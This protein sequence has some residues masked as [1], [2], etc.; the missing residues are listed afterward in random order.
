M[1]RLLLAFSC[2]SV[3]ASCGGGGG[4][5]TT[6]PTPTPTISLSASATSG[7]IA[8]GASSTT[9]LSVSRGGGFSGA[10]ALSAA[11]APSGVTVSFAPSSLASGSTSSTATISVDGTAAA[12][13]STITITASGSSVSSQSV[14]Y[15][16]TIPAPAI[17]LTA[18]AGT[19]TTAQGSSATVPLTITRVNGASSDV[20][21]SATGAPTGTTVSFAP[22]TL[23]SAQ[24][25]S[26][27]TLDVGSATAVG[28][29]SITVSAASSGVTTQTATVQLT[30]TA[31]ATPGYTLTATPAALSVT[32]GNGGTSAIAVARTGGFAGNVT[33]ALEGSPSG[34]TGSFAPNPATGNTSTLTITTTG[35]VTPGTYNLT[36]RGTAA[37]QTD[38]TIAF[39]LTVNAAPGITLTLAP[40]VLSIAQSANA[41]TA[42][43]LA[44]VGGLTG[45]VALSAT[46]APAGMTVVFNPA[47]VTA[48]AST[49]TVTVG[50]SVA[51][52][53]YPIT[54]TGTGTGSVTGTVTLTVTVTVAQGFTL[55]ATNASAVQGSTG[56]S[57]VTITRVGGFANNVDLT[58][59]NLPANVTAAFSPASVSGTS[60][61][62]TFT[63]SAG[64]TPGNYT[65][66]VNGTGT[67]ATNQSTTLTLTVTASGG[68]GGAIA[69]RFCDP[70]RVPLWFAYRDG[71]SG[72]WTRVTV[73]ANSTF[74]FTLAQ[75]VGAVAYVQNASGGGFQGTVFLNTATEMASV[76]TSEC[77]TNPD[78]KSL[79]ST[80]AGLTNNASQLQSG[81]VTIASGSGSASSAGT[82][83]AITSVGNRLADVFAYRQ[84]TNLSTIS[85]AIDKLI[86]RRSVNYAANSVV[87]VMDFDGAES[88]APATATIALS[89]AGADQTALITSFQT[90]NGPAGSLVNVFGGSTSALGVPASKTQAGDF[91]TLLATATASG[92]T[93]FRIV[94]QYNRDL[95]NRTLTFGNALALP[96]ITVTGAGRLKASGSW[97][98]EYGDAGASSITQG[99]GASSRSW[100]ISGSRGYFGAGSSGYEF[101]L[102]DFSGVT[103][104]LATWG[105]TTGVSAQITTN[106]TG[107][108]VGTYPQVAEGNSY[109]TAARVQ[110]ATP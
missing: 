89:N 11:G 24:T 51:T 12:G 20:T 31:A 67:G 96:T 93:A 32:V 23:T 30:V 7:T 79:T 102:F 42:L 19:A 101:E 110:N 62:L 29:Y 99:S 94:A 33:L 98:S 109:K 9:T 5:G 85:I 92:N 2:L 13:T 27:M 57:T 65:V 49:I 105:L 82:S 71:T 38:R 15:T 59:T 53:S 8:R 10:V 56:T 63:A 88:F 81:T 47:T 64:A 68:G 74:S 17:T 55:A 36:I 95:A 18:G 45:D 40:A 80:F 34:V 103:G 61:T 6:N 4:D 48:T 86:L 69:W 3:L 54:I 50:G 35:A 21:L 26:T 90:A 76:A 73:G 70:A 58:A 60:S 108:I 83:F 78:T 43:T 87:P 28:T 37:G 44:R 39:S 41:Q 52:G 25:S 16:L 107:S 97:T 100:T 66:T 84:T 77:A 72:A 91:H 75:S 104:Y 106:I 1:R 46:G 14:A 22:S